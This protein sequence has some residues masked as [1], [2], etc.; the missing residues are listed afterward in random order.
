M[1][2][3]KKRGNLWRI[4]VYDYTDENG[5][6]HN[7]SISAPTKAECEYKAIMYKSQR[8]SHTTSMT[9]KQAIDKYI[10]LRPLL[11]PTTLTAYLKMEKFAFQDIMDT[12][13]N[14][15]DDITIQK[16]VNK[17]AQR[18]SDRTGKPISIKTVKNE[19]GLLA[20]A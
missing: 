9:V 18:I 20:S 12:D 7:K 1:N 16:A 6:V 8:K 17:E 5:K 4:L 15:L 3:P 2:K 11:S 13:I 10:E 14:D 19:Y